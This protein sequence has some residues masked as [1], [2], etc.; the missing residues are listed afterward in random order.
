VP[1]EFCRGTSFSIVT[2]TYKKD[3]DSEDGEEG[4]SVELAKEVL[5]LK[6]SGEPTALELR[7]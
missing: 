5:V 1:V 2:S 6:V 7:I 4:G 3:V